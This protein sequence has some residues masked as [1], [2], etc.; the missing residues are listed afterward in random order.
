MSAWELFTWLN[1]GVLAV[2]SVAVFVLFVRQL[3][4][5]MGS[6]DDD[7]DDEPAER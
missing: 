2:G 5:L 7:D 4:E 6:G 1:V 3:P